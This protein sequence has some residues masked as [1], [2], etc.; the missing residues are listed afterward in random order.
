[1]SQ[2][3]HRFSQFGSLKNLSF[4]SQEV[5]KDTVLGIDGLQRKLL[6]VNRLDETVYT[7]TVVDLAKVKA[8]S[9]KKLYSAIKAGD[10]SNH[11]LDHHLQS[12]VL[13]FEM[14]TVET[15]VEVCFYRHIHDSVYSAKELEGKAKDW[16]TILSKMLRSPLVKEV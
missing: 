10:L 12:I 14:T 13:S 1:M 7:H 3:L 6:I 15:A 11:K 5:L 9:V 4:S 2:L 8:C 16:E